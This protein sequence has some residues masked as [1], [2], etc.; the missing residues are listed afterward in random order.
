VALIFNL[1]IVCHR[2]EHLSLLEDNK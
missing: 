2:P 1:S